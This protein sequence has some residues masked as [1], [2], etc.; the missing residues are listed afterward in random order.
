MMTDG[1]VQKLMI[2]LTMLFA[3]GTAL[4]LILLRIF[5]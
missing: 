2:A 1:I 5:G 3:A 4:A